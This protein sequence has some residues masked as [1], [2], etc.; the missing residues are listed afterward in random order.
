MVAR[1][2]D[3]TWVLPTE[4]EWYKSAYHY[5]DGVTTNYWDFPT[6]SDTAPWSEIPPGVNM[7]NGSANFFGS[8]F[9]V[10]APYYRTDVG[11]YDAK[12]SASPYGTF[13]Q[14]GNVFEW[15]EGIAFTTSRV[16]RGGAFYSSSDDL[17]SWNR[18]SFSPANEWDGFGFRVAH[19]RIL[20]SPCLVPEQLGSFQSGGQAKNVAIE[21]G[22]AYVANGD[23]EENSFG[24][25]WLGG[26]PIRRLRF[27]RTVLRADPRFTG[28]WRIVFPSLLPSASA[29]LR[30]R[31]SFH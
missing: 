29:A 19:T 28:G 26:I 31:R 21:G 5:N 14:G 22:I 18:N 11:A 12:P 3:A 6:C 7:D 25:Q 13:D 10:G 9:A 30:R 16:M 4:D 24:I 15:S 20:T 8:E 23:H 1:E 17:R 27:P 2:P